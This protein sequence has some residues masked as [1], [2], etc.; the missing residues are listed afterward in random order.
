MQRKQSCF[1]GGRRKGRKDGQ[2][3]VALLTTLVLLLLLTG[4]SLAMVMSV[5]SDMLVNGFYRNYRGSFYAADSGLNIVRNDFAL[6]VEAN[7][8]P[9]FSLNQQPI[10][11]GTDAI[12]L[13]SIQGKYNTPQKL[14][15]TGNTA[16]SWPESFQITNVTFQQ[17]SCTV[18]GGNNPCTN[19]TGNVTGYTYV[20][21]YS[22]TSVGHSKGTEQQT[23]IENGT[24]TLAA[25][26]AP[27]KTKTSFA[28]WGMFIDQFPICSGTL[29]PGTIT[30]PVF[31]N[32][33]W[34]FGT[35]GQYNFTDPVGSVSS[36][37]G[38]QFS[39]G[40]AQSSATSD[41]SNGVTIAPTFQSGFKMGQNKI[42]L[43]TDSYNQERA[44]LDGIGTAGQPT[45]T[46]LNTHLKN[47]NQTAYPAA[48][49]GANT[50]GVWLPYTTTDSLGN[51]IPP[52]FAG[53]GIMVQ[54]DA[55]VSLAPGAGNAQV[56][57]ITQGN[58]PNN[59]TLTQITIDPT[60][61]V[62]N[63]VSYPNGTTVMSSGGSNLLVSGVPQMRDPV[64]QQVTGNGA[65]LY[66]NGNI[67]SLQGPAQG[68]PALQNGTALTITAAGNVTITG[69]LLYSK[70][71]V[72]LTSTTDQNGNTVPPD[73]LIPANNS[74]Q[75][76]GI[77]TATG[78]IQLNNQQAVNTLEIDASL[79]MVSQGGSGGLVNTGSQLK[80]LTI[81]GG[82]IQNTIQNINTVT[83]NVF[84][85]RRFSQGG[86]S[87]PFFPSTTITPGTDSAQFQTPIFQTLNWKSSSPTSLW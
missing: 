83:R 24:L 70:E 47:I 39:S 41:T 2:R 74:G 56:Y 30:G 23:L 36:Q 9:T 51:A 69:D 80:T 32:G 26:L 49:N 76:L 13:A 85:D 63:G 48:G 31:T 84:F 62:I 10:P 75:V 54:G 38:Y 87:P 25:T 8:L 65:M 33:A 79:A 7:A 37:A 43:P 46:D 57:N 86:F 4:L 72:T 68:Q 15:G 6:Q 35:S 71:P 58:C 16:N 66:V 55:G 34:N 29:V 52:T 78:N 42:P 59:C 12:V 60:P 27:T 19:P 81:V 73:Q 40:C 3:G 77:F 21:S 53:G 5:K 18:N 61:T 11:P 45:Q 1:K 50:N 44:V 22:L 20:Y 82:R 14:T 67:T 64:T 17:S 28:A